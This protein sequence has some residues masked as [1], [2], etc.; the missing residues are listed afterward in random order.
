MSDKTER[1]TNAQSDVSVA[2]LL[3]GIAILV[4]GGILLIAGWLMPAQSQVALHPTILVMIG[5]F[6]IVVGLAALTRLM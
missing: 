5:A 2:R 1:N 4:L 3:G 6:L